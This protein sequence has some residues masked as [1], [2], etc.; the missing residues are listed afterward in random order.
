S[1][2]VWL[3]GAG[4]FTGNWPAHL[5]FYIAIATIGGAISALGE[6]LGWRGYLVPH[7][8]SAYGFT[9]TALISGLIWAAWHYPI[10]L[11]TDYGEGGPRW[12]LLLCFTIS[13]IGV[14]FVA[15]WL[16]LRTG[17]V[18]PAVLLHASHNIFVLNVFAPVIVQ[19][20]TTYL[21][22]GEGG[23][24]MASVAVLLAIIFWKL[25]S[26]LKDAESRAPD[27]NEPLVGASA[28]GGATVAAPASIRDDARAG[29]ATAVPG[30]GT[31][32]S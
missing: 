6:E 13:V 1:G 18:W 29:G 30:P 24:L 9:A 26:R 19:K 20:R 17:S 14:S 12:Y 3:I 31:D 7:L 10:L 21:L 15:A 5:P 4:S 32:R 22:T 11:F 25:R 28:R 2:V 8:A 23:L 27:A 16:R